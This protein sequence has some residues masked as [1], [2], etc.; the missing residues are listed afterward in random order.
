MVYSN[1]HEMIYTVDVAK[2]VLAR[3][4][5]PSYR[6]GLWYLGKWRVYRNVAIA[7]GWTK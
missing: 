7:L 1:G 5:K 4:E 6:D 3:G 2:K